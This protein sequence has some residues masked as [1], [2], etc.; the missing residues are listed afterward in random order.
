ML[1][2]L[3]LK[4][5]KIQKFCINASFHAGGFV[6]QIS[7]DLE[8]LYK[9]LIS[10]WR[11]CHSN[12]I[13]PRNSVQMPHIMLE[14]LS[15]KSVKIQKF[16]INASFHAGGF[17][18]QI[19]S[20]LEILYRCLISCWRLCPSNQSR[21]R[22]SVQMPHF[23]LEALSLKSDQTQKFCIDAS[24]H[25]G[26]FVTQIRSDLEILYRC[27]IS[28]W[29]LCHSNQSRS[30]NSVQMPHFM[31]EALSLKSDQT[32]KFCIDAS[33]HA[34]GFV[35]QISQNLEILYRCLISCWR[36]CHSNQI[37]PRNSVQMPHFMLEALSLKSGETQKFCI[38]ASYHAGDFVPQ[39]SQDLEILYRC[40]ISCWRLCHSNQI[41]PRNSVQM[42]H[43]MLEA[44]SLKSG[45]IQKFC[46]DA[47]YHAGDFVPQISQDLE[48]LYR[49]LISC[50]RP[51]H[52]NK[53][54]PRNSK[55][56]KYFMIEETQL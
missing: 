2:A 40:L 44:L 19:R 32:Q 24:F 33:Y 50:W 29:R 54:R 17:V 55:C 30:R 47:S 7:Q 45:E 22:N 9:C 34:G 8:I 21:S 16:C 31:L 27:L 4:S 18:T 41:R 51:C 12:Q 28:C 26:D 49:C 38:D 42:P 13:R 53:V 25:A 39:I 20:D 56:I 36:L 48:I 14:A 5:V 43:F 15:L 46:I 37:R 23:M 6:P 1:E 10:C 35:T 3:S 52:S 11:L